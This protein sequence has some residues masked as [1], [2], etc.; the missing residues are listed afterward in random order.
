MNKKSRLLIIVSVLG[1]AMIICCTLAF[2]WLLR[3]QTREISRDPKD[4]GNWALPEKYSERLIFPGEIPDT[5]TE[6]V[7]Y[8]KYQDGWGRPMCQ[9]FLQC[10]LAETE[11]NAEVSRLGQ[12][13]SVVGD[14]QLTVKYDVESF[15]YPAYVT[16]EGYDFCY[17]YALINEVDREIIYAYAMN[18]MYRD[19]GYD[20]KYLP[21]YFMEGF[22]DFSVDGLERFTIYGGYSE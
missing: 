18:T 2:C 8:Y 21:D 1:A 10:R 12:I 9:I 4:Y 13:S 11:F 16:I 7:Y 19:M 5:A 22:E 17:E 3:G 14:E 15:L 6:I 20:R